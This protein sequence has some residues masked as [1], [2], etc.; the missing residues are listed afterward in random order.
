[1]QLH[2]KQQVKPGIVTTGVDPYAD[3][4]ERIPVIPE[5]SFRS[6][7]LEATP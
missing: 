3:C 4:D 7:A 5:R 1:M 2:P 6:Q